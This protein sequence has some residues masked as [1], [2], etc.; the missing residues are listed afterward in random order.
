MTTTNITRDMF[1]TVNTHALRN[2]DLVSTHG[3]LFRIRD[4]AEHVMGGDYGVTVSFKT[5][6]VA[7]QPDST[8]PAHWRKDWTI[9]GNGLATWARVNRAKLK[10]ALAA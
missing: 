10:A 6:V 5:D 8:M 7:V 9:Q 2:G 3:V 4:R 1:E